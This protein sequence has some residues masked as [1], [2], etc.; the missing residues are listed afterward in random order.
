MKVFGIREGPDYEYDSRRCPAILSIFL[1]WLHQKR[2]PRHSFL[3]QPFFHQSE[4][5]GNRQVQRREMVKNS[6]FL[7]W[8]RSKQAPSY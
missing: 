1:T 7:L 6:F 5:W 3:E 2:A 4:G 8:N